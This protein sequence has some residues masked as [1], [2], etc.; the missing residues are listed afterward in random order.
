M[1]A[2]VHTTQLETKHLLLREINPEVMEQLFSLP[3]EDEYIKSFL[4][5]LSNEEL[6]FERLKFQKGL[7]THK[8]TFR[9]FVMI[10]KATSKPVGKCGFHSWYPD[11]RRAEIGY[12]FTDE[13]YKGKGLMTEALKEMI[14]Y[15]FEKMELNR[16][17]AFVGPNNPAS[18]KLIRSLGFTEEGQLREHY[19][20]HPRLEDSI[21]FSLLKKEYE[22]I[23]SSW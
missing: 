22:E 23:K 3:F 12:G 19:Y 2:Q 1:A 20:K 21:C 5:L 9:N 18:L 7:V 17:E 13:N 4:G 6:E 8:L 10:D 11:H 14:K 15:G 16:V